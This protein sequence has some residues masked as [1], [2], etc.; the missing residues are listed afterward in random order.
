MSDYSLH[1]LTPAQV[2]APATPEE[3]AA[4]LRH[5]SAHGLAVVPWGGGTRQQIG[6]APARYDIALSTHALSKIVEYHPAD[7]VITV[8]AGVTLGAIQAELARHGQWLPWDVP[9]AAQASVGGLLASGAVGS[10]R[11][12]Y[13]PPRD[14]TLGMC[15]ALGDG[16]LVRSG[17]KVVKNVA[18]YDTHKLQ[19]GALGTLGVIVEATFKLAPLP[20]C[21]QTI[22]AAFTD[23]HLPGRAIEQLRTAPLQPIALVALNRRAE[24]T[25]TPLHAFLDGQP[26]HIVVAA[27]FAGTARAVGRQI[28]EATRRCIEVG[29]RTVELR[30]ED[31]TPLWDAIADTMA[32]A[33]DHSLLLRAGVPSSAFSPLAE[34]LERT[35]TRAG[36]PAAQ[37]GIAGVGI[38]YSR[39]SVAG[40]TPSAV[41]EAL[42]A[43]RTEVIQ[44][45]GYVVVEE[46]PPELAG[47]IDIWGPP[48]EGSEL[49][50]ALRATWDPAGILNPGRVGWASSGKVA[51]LPGRS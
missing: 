50:G 43:V 18:G 31:D 11:L 5:A 35:A 16:R 9:L 23:P 28:R 14:W 20:E 8:E 44:L 24:E 39:W 49:M 2:L 36:W 15:V 34:L 6:R 38:V 7:L 29:A 3:L 33:R 12:G 41:A 4:I 27:R 42:A 13:G 32:P 37:L 30:E 10:L 46:A 1:N 17:G 40:V 19:I 21:R 22:L 48:P 51:D 47:A 45:G 25:V 26:G